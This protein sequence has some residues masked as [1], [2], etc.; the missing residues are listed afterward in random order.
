MK[1]GALETAEW[2]QQPCPAWCTVEHTD[3]DHPDDRSHRD[4]GVP[5]PIVMRTRTVVDGRMADQTAEASLVTGRWQRDGDRELWWSLGIDGDAS[6]E[7]TTESL[8]RVVETLQG[9]LAEA[10]ETL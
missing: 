1:E 7:V 3:H 9:L 5:V 4:D 6:L 8:A 10:Q 2:Q